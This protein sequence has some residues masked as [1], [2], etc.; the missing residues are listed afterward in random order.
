MEGSLYESG[1]IE[2]S[3][4]YFSEKTFSYLLDNVCV[5]LTVCGYFFNLRCGQ[6]F[7]F[8]GCKRL[9]GFVLKFP[10]TFLLF[11]HCPRYCAQFSG[12]DERCVQ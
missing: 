8:I 11:E 5:L 2:I 6:V 4:V 1:S 7:K 12:Y 10:F 3:A 9:Y